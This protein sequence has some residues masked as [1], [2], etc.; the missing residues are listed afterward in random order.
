MKLGA[1]LCLALLGC[2][3]T[4]PLLQDISDLSTSLV[5]LSINDTDK[6]V[7]LFGQQ[8]LV[9]ELPSQPSTGFRWR[10]NETP[11]ITQLGEPVF[12]PE[13]NRPGTSG[14]VL[15]RFKA[16]RDAVSVLKFLYDR[17]WSSAPATQV[18]QFEIRTKGP[19]D[20][21]VDAK[22]SAPPE[23]Q[24]TSTV[25]T[26]VG[27]NF[28]GLQLDSCIVDGAEN[29]PSSFSWCKSGRCT[30]VKEQGN[31]GSCWAFAATAIF[32]SAIIRKDWA[33]RDLSEQY[34]VSCNTDLYGCLGGHETT[35][36]E[37]HKSKFGHLETSAG[38][39]YES[40]FPYTATQQACGAA[41]P[42]H[43]TISE[44]YRLPSNPSRA[45]IKKM[46]LQYGPATADIC[47]SAPEFL[48]YMGGIL[49]SSQSCFLGIR[50]HAVAIV[51]WD[52]STSS[53]IIKN[54]WGTDWGEAGYGRIA[55]DTLNMAG[56]VSVLSF[57]GT[58][59]R[60]SA[61]AGILSTL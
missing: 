16:N 59:S 19:F 25:S 53:W 43:E 26:R 5:H 51:G 24:S 52:D 45:C 57:S 37:Y 28:A 21:E 6:P 33:T 29:F 11:A 31:C 12:L 40:D 36:H 4:T 15:F 42:H 54:S 47:G 30:P 32:E 38:A 46:I 14:R 22:A 58:P 17:P 8:T 50:D 61:I 1:A 9:I 2:E 35:A 55:Y 48:S 7:V 20:S 18:A 34:L 44:W 3:P 60:L 39:V 10:V 23:S 49:D 27:Q 41:H 13:T 56:T